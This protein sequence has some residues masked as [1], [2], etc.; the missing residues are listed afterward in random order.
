MSLSTFPLGQCSS[1][2][3]QP[4]VGHGAGRNRPLSI[5][6]NYHPI[7]SLSYQMKACFQKPWLS[8]ALCVMRCG[9]VRGQVLLTQRNQSL[10]L[11]QDTRG[12]LHLCSRHT[13]PS[14]TPRPRSAEGT[15]IAPTGGSPALVCT[16][17]LRSQRTDSSTGQRNRTGF[18]EQTEAL[19]HTERLCLDLGREQRSHQ[20]QN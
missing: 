10:D 18:Q 14:P 17:P 16:F 7:S 13:E 3:F 11:G 5:P 12:V 15:L 8:R 9:A 20:M 1:T 6:Q 2:S 19:D 4:G